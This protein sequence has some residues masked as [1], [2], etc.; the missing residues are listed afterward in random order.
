MGFGSKKY[1]K[2]IV[3]LTLIMFF[4]VIF[5]SL[6]FAGFQAGNP[7]HSIEKMY[8]PSFDVSG[9]TN[10]S[11]NEEPTDSLFSAFFDD[12]PGNSVSLQ[13]LLNKNPAYEHSCIPLDC[14]KDYSAGNG[15]S[16]K[17]FTLNSGDSKIWGL[18][19]S[20]SRPI[21][22]ISSFSM[23]INSNAAPSII[24]QLS[25]DIS[26]DD[27]IDWRAYKPSG[28]YQEKNYGCFEGDK[29]EELAQITT[30]EYCQKIS[31]PIFPKVRIGANVQ[32][33]SGGNVNFTMSIRNETTG[34]SKYCNQNASDSG[35]ISCI[36][37]DLKT[38]QSQDFFVCIKTKSTE[39]NDKYGVK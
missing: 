19:I 12:S 30:T 8:G 37:S 34:Q 32:K 3:M 17:I 21:A 4:I 36:I 6:V 38:D 35:Q 1:A 27:E 11:F 5:T 22:S 33:I 15:A 26:D 28:Q 14:G 29:V 10:I 24:P 18:R 23:K 13:E 9:W 7:S 25:I 2:E 39:D 20:S 31:M 16:S